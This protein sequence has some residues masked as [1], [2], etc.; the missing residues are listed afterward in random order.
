MPTSLKSATVASCKDKNTLKAKAHRSCNQYKECTNQITESEAHWACLLHC[1][2]LDI[3]QPLPKFGYQLFHK[4]LLNNLKELSHI[5]YNKI[6]FPFHQIKWSNEG[7]PKNTLF[8]N[9]ILHNG[10]LTYYFWQGEENIY[11][12]TKPSTPLNA[13][14]R[15][16]M[17]K[18]FLGDHFKWIKPISV[19]N[20]YSSFPSQ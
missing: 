3:A 2:R 5:M 20:K 19:S 4:L 13:C 11:H 15:H 12:Q 16:V 14:C 6:R 8:Q 9:Y 1:S 7:N 10:T 18:N 17:G